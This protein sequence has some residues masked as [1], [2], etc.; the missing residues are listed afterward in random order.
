MSA[1]PPF[2]V[3]FLQKGKAQCTTVLF[4]CA[5]SGEQP[6]RCV[7]GGSGPGATCELS[8]SGC[9]LTL[10]APR[11]LGGC[12]FSG[13]CTGHTRQRVWKCFA[14]LFELVRVCELVHVWMCGCARA[15][16]SMFV[17]THACVSVLVHIRAHARVCTHS[18]R[19]LLQA[20]PA[21]WGA[22]VKPTFLPSP[23]PTLPYG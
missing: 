20:M 7:L 23:G 19:V 2:L 1:W 11:L 4:P 10:L 15:H 18:P 5:S 9:S 6:G 3:A 12:P 16:V 22:R 8:G 17:G 13:A 14:S 21:V